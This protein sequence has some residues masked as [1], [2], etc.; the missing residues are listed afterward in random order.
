LLPAAR[1][2]YPNAPITRDA[3]AAILVNFLG[4]GNMAQQQSLFKLPFSDA[5]SIPAAY[6]G[7]AA[8]ANAYH[9]IP[10]EDGKWDPTASLTVAEA[11]VAIV[12]TMQLETNG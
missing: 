11:S 8:I 5:S 6:K 10:S 3:A 12:R 4:W 2:F 7:D 9:M 1:D